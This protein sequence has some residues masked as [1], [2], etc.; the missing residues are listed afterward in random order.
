MGPIDWAIGNNTSQA[1][2]EEFVCVL[3]WQAAV[4]EKGIGRSFVPTQAS[5]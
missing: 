3:A 1:D 4:S 5:N 2:D